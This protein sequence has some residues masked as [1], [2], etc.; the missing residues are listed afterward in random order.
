MSAEENMAMAR[1]FM[2]AQV[3]GDL[4]YSNDQNY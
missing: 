1:R 3:M 2:E 4:D